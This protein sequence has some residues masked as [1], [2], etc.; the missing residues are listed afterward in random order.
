MS[1]ELEVLFGVLA[2]AKIERTVFVCGRTYKSSPYELL[3]V[4][5][6]LFLVAV[7]S[8]SKIEKFR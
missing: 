2:G 4:Q 1:Y 6:V 3:P 5:R 8:K 7:T